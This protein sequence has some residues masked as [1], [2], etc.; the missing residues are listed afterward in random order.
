MI[1]FED[2]FNLGPAEARKYL[3]LALSLGG[4]FAE[5]YCEYRT[6]NYINM[7]E[8][9]IK[10]TAESVSL[11]L[12]IRVTTGDQT[13][14]GYTNDL[15]PEK[16]RQTALTAA[17]IAASG[18]S[19]SASPL[20]RIRPKAGIY[21]LTQPLSSTNMVKKIELVCAAYDACQKTDS[22]IKKVRVLFQDHVQHVNIINS[23]G[24]FAQDARPQAKLVCFAMAE[25]GQRRESGFSGG[26]GRVGLEYFEKVLTPLQIGQEAAREALRLLEAV[27]APAGEMPVVLA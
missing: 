5:I 17:A 23:E 19:G 12:G 24:V 25:K 4:D 18:K 9:I 3:K 7:E 27:E 22:K 13:G 16:I 1:S 20:R 11:G 21:P 2:H 26:G 6:Y 8:D 10:E 14:Y 15:S